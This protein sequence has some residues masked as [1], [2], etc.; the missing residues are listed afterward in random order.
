MVDRD[1]RREA[2]D[3]VN[4]GLVHKS[5]KLPCVSG[6]RFNVAALTFGVNSV[7]GEGGL[8]RPTEA[9][10]DDEFV[11]RDFEADVFEVVNARPDD[12]DEI[13]HSIAPD[14][15]I[16]AH[17]LTNAAKTFTILVM[18]NFCVGGVIMRMTIVVDVQND[19]VDGV[20][21]TSEA[22]D[23][24]PNLVKKLE[25]IKSDAENDL[26]FTQDTHK[27]NY[28]ET[29]EGKFL[30]VVHCL[31]NTSGWDLV[32]EV[33]PFT[34]GAMVIEKASFGTT[35]LPSLLKKYDEV[36]FCGLCTDICVI[37][38]ALVVKAF[39]PEKTILIDS[40]CC[41]GVTPE[42][43]EAALLVMKNCGCVIS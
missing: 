27:D 30:P 17:L 18:T 6:E 22:L 42:T 13:F 9:G 4:V 31:K 10:D 24:I 12:F 8:A 34:E 3:L 37:S 26:I 2:F 14:I 32:R 19:F 5:K 21:G 29:A 7:E 36:E 33:R 38:N 35:R 40:K 41:A 1:C 23:M 28:L 16:A 15:Q 20:L 25:G 43:H 11:A 39:Y